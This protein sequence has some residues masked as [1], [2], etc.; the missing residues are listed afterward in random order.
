MATTNRLVSSPFVNRLVTSAVV[1]GLLFTSF[2]TKRF[3]S[4]TRLLG[5]DDW[6]FVNYGCE[7]DPPMALPL[8]A[9]DEP[10]R[11]FIQRHH[12]RPSRAAR[13]G[14]TANAGQDWAQIQWATCTE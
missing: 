8:A 4:Q 5:G 9:S 11:F 14:L 3:A 12:R 2:V 7:E 1:F 6:L 13:S 10:H